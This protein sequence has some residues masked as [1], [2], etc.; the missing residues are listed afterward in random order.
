TGIRHLGQE[1]IRDGVKKGVLL[2]TH[3]HWDHINGFPF[4]APAF[5]PNNSFAIYAGH[6]SKAGGIQSVLASQM[7]NPTFPVPLE[8]LQAALKFEDF[9]A[10]LSWKLDGGVTIKTEPL[11]HPNGAT[12]YRIE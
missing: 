8:A 12:G 7:A 5:M 6:L 3:S 10:G 9:E 1:F 4:F 11:N 2:L